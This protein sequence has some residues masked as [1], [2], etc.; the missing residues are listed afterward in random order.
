MPVLDYEFA[1]SKTLIS[2]T[3]RAAQVSET[4]TFRLTFSNTGEGPFDSFELA[5]VYDPSLLSFVGATVAPDD[6]ADDG[7]LNWTGLGPLATNASFSIDVSFLTLAATDP[8]GTNAVIGTTTNY[9]PEPPKTNEVPYDV[10]QP[11]IEVTKTLV[12]PVGR[13][14]NVGETVIFALGVSN[15]S[16]VEI[17]NIN[18]TDSYDTNFLSFVGASPATVD[19]MDDGSLAWSP[20]DLAPGGSTNF[21][22]TFTA[23]ASTLGDLT[24]NWVVGAGETTNGVPVG[25]ETNNAP[26]PVLDYEFAV[27]KTLISP[28]GRAAQVSETL[29]FRLTFSNTGE[30]PFDSFELADVY[31][32]SLLSFVGATVAPDDAADDGILNWTGLG[33]LATNASF[34][35]D[36]S[37]LTLAATDP[38]GTNAVI[39]TT[40]NYLPEPPKTNEVPY[41]V[42][43]PG[44]EV[45]KTL[46]SPVGRPANVGETVIFALGVS[47][48]S[49]V[50]IVNINVTDNYDTNFLSF[51]GASPATVDMMDDG[52]LAWSPFDLAPGGSTNFTVTFTAA[53]STLGDLT[54]NW[55]VGAGETTNG[56]PVGPETNN[57]PV[58][59]LDYEFA[60]SKTLISPTGRAAQV[61]ETLTFRLTFSNTGEGP[62]DSFELADV[63]DPSLLSFVG[64]T[65]APD[66]AADD[67]I[68]NW[69]GLGP[70]AT[71]A[72]FS[73]D[74]SFL[75]LAATDPLGTNAVIGTTTNY[76]P[77]PP[78]T[79]EVPYDVDQPGIEVTKTLVSPTGRPANV[80][81]TVVFALGVSNTSLVEIVNINVT[82]S[83]DTNFLSFVGASPATV[84]MMDD[85]SLAWSPFDLAPGGST[86]FT[87]TFTAAASTLGDLT[88]NWVVGAG[89]TTNGVP[90]GPETN[91]APVPVLDYEFAV[92]KTLI[93]PTGRAAQVSETLTF[94]LTFS[95]TGEGPF[96]SFELADV[97]DPSLLSFVGATVAPD[98]A[99]DDGI[100]NWTGLGP[101]ATNA[102]FSI[103]VSFLTLAATDPL[104]TNAVIGT[105]TNYP[106][107]PPKTNEVPYDVDQPGIEV[108]KTLV[109]PVG[110]PANV[111]ETVIFALGVSNTSLVEIV[112]INVTDSYDTNF[113]SFVGASPATVDMMDDGSLAWSPFDL[114]PGGST[115][116]TVTFTAAASTLG[117][118][119]TN[120]VV[121]AGETTNGVP[122]G[123]ETNNAPVPVAQY[124]CDMVKTLLSPTGRAAQVSEVIRFRLSFRNSGEVEIPAFQIFDTYDPAVLNFHNA[125]V[126]PD[127]ATDDGSLTWSV[128]GPLATGASYNIDIE[129]IAADATMPLTTNQAVGQILAG[130]EFL[131]EEEGEDE[132][133]QPNGPTFSPFSPPVDPCLDTA[134]LAI[135]LPGIDVTK[136]LL[137]PTGRPANAGET[138]AF[139]LGVSNTSL[140]ELVNIN[141]TDSYDTSF[142]SFVGASPATVDL[143]DDGNLAWPLFALAPGVSTNFIVTFTATASTLGDLT[144]NWVVGAGE[145]TNGVP[146]GPETNNAPVP[147]LDYEFAVS[148]TLISPT[149]RAAQVSET[150]T[151]R[152]TFSN[153]GEGAFDSFELADVYDPS[154]L[155][156]VGATVAP[157]DATDDGLL[158]WTGLGP[159]ATNASFSIDVSFLTLAATDPLGTNAVIGTTTNVPPEPPRTN[160]V[161]FHVD[162]PGIEVTKTLLSPTGRPANVGETV[163]FQLGISNTSLV[164]LVN[165]DMVDTYDTAYLSYIGAANPATVD[166]IDDGSLAWPQFDLVAGGSANLTVSFVTVASTLGDLTTNWVI[167]AGET[168]NGVPIRPETNQAP[169]PVADYAFDLVKQQLAPTNPAQASDVFRFRLTFSNTGEVEI[170]EF[171]IADQYDITYLSYLGADLLP[172]DATDDGDLIWTGLGPL[173]TGAS[174]SIEVDFLALTATEPVTTNRAIGTTTNI[175]PE[176]P[177]TSDVPVEVFEPQIELIKELIQPTNAPALVGD[178]LL[179]RITVRNTGVVDVLDFDL[180]DNYDNTHIRFLDASVAPDDSTDDGQLDWTGLGLISVG[181]EFVVTTR[182]LAVGETLPPD[183]VFQPGDLIPDFNEVIADPTNAPPETS[184]VPYV[185]IV[186]VEVGDYVWFDEDRDGIQDDGEPG[187]SNITVVLFDSNTMAIATQQTDAAGSYLFTNL[188]P[189]SYSVQ[190]IPPPTMAFS[191][192][193][194]TIYW[195]D[196]N[197]DPTTGR[198][199]PTAYLNGT[200]TRFDYSLDAGLYALIPGIDVR[201]TT[202]TPS[203]LASETAVFDLSVT[204]TGDLDLMDVLVS[205]PLAP[206]CDQLIALL[207]V[208]GSVSWSC[209]LSNVL[210][211]LT[212]VVTACGTDE[213]GRVVCATDDVPVVVSSPSYAVDKRLIMPTDY[214]PEIGGAIRYELEVTNLSTNSLPQFD[215]DDVYDP[216][217][218]QFVTA[219]VTPDSAMSGALNW[220]GLGPLGGQETFIVQV[221]FLAIAATPGTSETV[222]RAIASVTNQ[223]PQTNDVP[224]DIVGPGLA[225]TKMLLSPLGRPAHIG[226]TVSFALSVVNTGEVDLVNVQLADQYDTAILRYDGL[227]NPATVDAIN[228]GYIA[229]MPIDLAVGDQ[230]QVEVQFV[231]IAS[232]QGDPSTNWVVAS[233]ETTNGTPVGPETN[234]APVPVADYAHTIEKTVLLPAGQSVQVGEQISFR[235]TYSNTGEAEIPAFDMT[236]NYDVSRLRFLSASLSP[237]DATD[238]GSLRWGPLGPLGTNS[239]FSID[240]TFLALA[241][242][243][244]INQAVGTTTNE[245]PVTNEVPVEVDGPGLVVS[246]SL[247]SPLGRP[248]N[249]GEQV[250]F[251]LDIANTG[252]VDL[253]NVML[254]DTYDP[255]T[256][257]YRGVASPATVDVVDDGSLAWAPFTLLPGDSRS[258][259]VQFVALRSTLPG[260]TT[261]TV[262]GSGETTNGVPVGPITNEVPVPIAEFA[263]DLTKERIDPVGRDLQVGDIATFRLTFVNTGPAIIPEFEITDTYDPSILSFVDASRIPDDMTDD[264]TLIWSGL[265]PIGAGESFSINVRFS[266]IAEGSTVNQGVGSTTNIPPEPPVTN[267]VPETVLT[268][269]FTVTKTLVGPLGRP[270]N[271]G[272]TVTFRLQAFNG[273]E[274]DLTD[275]QLTDRYDTSYLSYQGSATPASVDTVDDGELAWTGVDLAV[276]DSLDVFVSFVALQSTQR[277][278]TT[279]VVVG[280]A[281]TT[282][283]TP[284]PP[285]TNEAPL[286]IADFAFSFEKELIQPAGRNLE[287][288][289][290]ADFR[291]T[292]R[293]VGD[294]PILEFEIADQYD[295]ALLR[296]VSAD[297][298]PDSPDDDG[299]L[300]WTGLGPIA[301][302][303]SFSIHARFL[304]M[305]EGRG[306]NLG[307]G[308]TTNTPP[309]PPITNDVPVNIVAPE[310]TVVKTL[311]RPLGRPANVGETVVFR[312]D[313]TNTGEVDL[314]A[315]HVFDRYDAAILSYQGMATPSTVD[316]IDDGELTWPAYPLAVGESASHEVH[317]AAVASTQPG[318]TINVVIADGVTTSG[319]LVGPVT[320]EA[321]VPV[322]EYAFDFRKELITPSDRDAQVGDTI[323]F[324]LTYENTGEVAIPQFEITD[325]Y[326][327]SVL[328]FLSASLAPADAADDGALM[329]EHSGTAC[330]GR[331]LQH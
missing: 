292:F 117:D 200:S 18:V 22:V 219:S 41:D 252:R 274:L 198:T 314:Q 191:P 49:L 254:T 221:E 261:N 293:N 140:V 167:G 143:I 96:D 223:P 2:P 307:I 259:T 289:E 23:A 160:E 6:A 215:L 238:D 235:L 131:E 9:P 80:G 122:V 181:G 183:I 163:V 171:E 164:E 34:S 291:L 216:E 315:V 19:M 133:F 77:E 24:T 72:S 108:T 97:Y 15:T 246:K 239:S 174:F 298:A 267:E 14:A 113:L 184:E 61:S 313:V 159:L 75:T 276:G 309:E 253:V 299:S 199:A 243:D 300:I 284:L 279:N 44:I 109:S 158:N 272:E 71:N 138:V 76:P 271:V 94:R 155:S 67:G 100:L 154:L 137:S 211:D 66:D 180:L 325:T 1:V 47:N 320:N 316:A 150:M 132:Q 208:G 48:T 142:L 116:F 55:V 281:I 282:N 290:F 250:S 236:D 35:I 79:N 8:L 220:Q 101:L 176:P 20:F 102:S 11:G 329:W 224:T 244:T 121:G 286:P 173:P 242:G 179:F 168:T 65:V 141:L 85:G 120:W 303:D 114:A 135:N 98:D 256:L 233:A 177:V 248:A 193:Y 73:I 36:V 175:P 126:S 106:P 240:V 294:D 144:T 39:G 84:D 186:P 201:K 52:S 136:T 128:I 178:E 266:A 33:P 255:A 134:T 129:F 110:R 43:Q 277:D 53:A 74:V 188:P 148:K 317:F 37:F 269:Q 260:V 209:T 59:V 187:V 319:T 60:V 205:D 310:L 42:D 26:V 245:P 182:F 28:T 162:L 31:D 5:D 111:G 166:T 149:G 297:L 312:L 234:E 197:A 189:G 311:L 115:N 202:R 105:T 87:V 331:Q 321:P 318:E 275:V 308:S 3:G 262:T 288:G 273:G 95:N 127:D 29:T 328:S 222:N 296:F 232:T 327:A 56:V 324:R 83:Y 237:D 54:T 190:F 103:D 152:L 268:P 57:A 301:S 203:L 263:F 265:G 204:N 257:S 81:E 92:S 225:V 330:R 217:T 16:L 170:P 165:I 25:P 153:T 280:T 192:P 38:L 306:L 302:G 118:L 304:A 30:G 7:I 229:W 99:A 213:F 227:A 172:D 78:K 228:D 251:R 196:S 195:R 226:E 91:N 104:G 264:G 249:I 283:G 146:V 17:V 169:V 63:Y 51:V 4:L 147:V 58:P 125:S 119:T 68:L 139:E 185:V 278:R 151:F 241:E 323:H 210:A 207:P 218:L 322:A 89:E 231:A 88:T 247:L 107:E 270:A 90:V 287:V 258:V 214:I 69:T 93:S 12:S 206:S 157:D 45:T 161:P 50:E 285:V 295:P 230:A 62:F 82:D 13:P 86:N 70:L 130:F 212:N 194:Q 40:T 305:G 112:N 21:T 32:P 10:D 156:F 46:V 64:A 124:A 123:P 326:D 145:T 27:S